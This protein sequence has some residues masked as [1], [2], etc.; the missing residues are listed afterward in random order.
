M[1]RTCPS[2]IVDDETA[3]VVMPGAGGA[4]GVY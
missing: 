2:L 4:G 3:R 1:K